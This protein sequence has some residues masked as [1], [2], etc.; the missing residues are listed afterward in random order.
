MTEPTSSSPAADEQDEPGLLERIM[1]RSGDDDRGLAEEQVE[2]QEEQ[3]VEQEEQGTE[4]QPT[5]ATEG[6]ASGRDGDSESQDPDGHDDLDT[7]EDG[8]PSVGAMPDADDVDTDE[9]EK[10][11]QERL[12]PDNRPDHVEIDNTDRTFDSEKGMFTDGEGYDEAEAKYDDD[13]V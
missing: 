8:Q 13:A 9:I 2:A 6:A 1:G 7:D 4:E 10:E 5:Q 3:V 11:R 12:D